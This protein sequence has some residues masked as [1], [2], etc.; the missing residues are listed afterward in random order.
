MPTF[1]YHSECRYMEHA[2]FAVETDRDRSSVLPDAACKR[3]DNQNAHA[4]VKEFLNDA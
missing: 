1:C 2:G 4:R 3:D